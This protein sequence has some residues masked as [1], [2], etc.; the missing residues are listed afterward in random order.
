MDFYAAGY[1]RDGRKWLFL[2]NGLG[3]IDY[4]LSLVAALLALPDIYVGFSA[5][6]IFAG[7]FGYFLTKIREARILAG[8]R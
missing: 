7:I 4:H 8:T 6:F 2:P 5:G 3:H 1:S